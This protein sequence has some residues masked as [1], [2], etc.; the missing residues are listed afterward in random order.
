MRPSI[1]PP[2]P[3]DE[4]DQF[5]DDL[6][7]DLSPRPRQEVIDSIKAWRLS[8]DEQTKPTPLDHP[9]RAMPI[10]P[11]PKRPFWNVRSPILQ[12]FVG[13]L[14]TAGVLFIGYE[15]LHYIG[16]G[17]GLIG[18]WERIHV[19]HLPVLPD[20]DRIFM[21]G[22]TIVLPVLAIAAMCYVIKWIYLFTRWIGA[23][24]LQQDNW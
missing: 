22:V 15:V 9:Y 21:G 17:L 11:A 1:N 6:D 2:V 24:T 5:S 18:D 7:G 13:L 19:E 23:I 14:M 16:R 8:D 3:E 10:P 4:L 12:V 20:N